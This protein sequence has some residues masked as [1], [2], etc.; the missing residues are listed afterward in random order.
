MGDQP[1]IRSLEG[2]RLHVRLQQYNRM[3]KMWKQSQL[4][5]AEIALLS[6]AERESIDIIRKMQAGTFEKAPVKQTNAEWLAENDPHDFE[7]YADLMRKGK[8]ARSR[9]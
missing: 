9:R 8:L 6:P 1:S 3:I 7:I 2:A 4:S 5:P